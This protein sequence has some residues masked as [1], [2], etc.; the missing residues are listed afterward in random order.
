VRHDS[1]PWRAPVVA[2]IVGHQRQIVKERGGSNPSVRTF[3]A[4]PSRL[5]GNRLRGAL[6]AIQKANYKLECAERSS[7]GL[8]S[9]IVARRNINLGRT[10]GPRVFGSAHLDYLISYRFAGRVSC[11]QVYRTTCL[12]LED[13]GD[14]RNSISL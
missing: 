3:D 9:V 8:Q 2:A 11:S 5:G 12:K 1:Q 7:R 14:Q 13:I 4:E 10:S 6:A